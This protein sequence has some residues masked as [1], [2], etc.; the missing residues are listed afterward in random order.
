MVSSKIPALD[1]IRSL[2][3]I[4][5]LCAHAKEYLVEVVHQ[6]SF[7][8]LL[9]PFKG[10]WIGVDLFFSLS[11]FLI[12]RQVWEELNLT[13]T[14]RFWRFFLRRG[15][16]IWP[17]FYAVFLVLLIFPYDSNVSGHWVNALFLSNLLGDNGPIKG[18]W[19]LATE[20]QFYILLPLGFMFYSKIVKTIDL[21]TARYG[22]YALLVVPMVMRIFVWDVILQPQHFD[23]AL[24]MRSIYRP[25]YTHSDSL[26]SGLILSNLVVDGKFP[27]LP[28]KWGQTVFFG[29]V[30]V[31]LVSF[32][33]KVYFNFLGVA[34]ASTGLIWF[35]L[36]QESWLSKFLSHRFFST[37]A[38]VSFCM[39]LVNLPL[40]FV[41]RDS[42]LMHWPNVPL[43]V[44][45]VVNT[46]ILTGVCVLIGLITYELIERPFLKIRKRFI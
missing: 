41:W 28:R 46:I 14:V 4:F 23:L 37:I 38:R 9:P 24:Y 11:G 40:L 7:L 35:C 26:I 3:I 20:E 29:L 44:L 34:L 31:G 8:M 27:K 18:A 42:G 25:I 19:S 12:G 43:D 15:F 30:I 6:E 36:N 32:K 1:G 17:L 39:Y 5:V 2:A 10:G 22:L 33:S 16:R 13:G 21:T 45:L